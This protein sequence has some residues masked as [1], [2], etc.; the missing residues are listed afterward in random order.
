MQI[1]QHPGV[2][3]EQKNFHPSF[4]P[5]EHPQVKENSA[6]STALTIAAA[7]SFLARAPGARPVPDESRALCDWLLANYS[8]LTRFLAGSFNKPWGRALART[9]EAASIPGILAHYLARKGAIETLVAE[10][11]QRQLAVLGAGFDTLAVRMA[12][13]HP[14]WSVWE[15]DHPATQAWKVRAVM[16]CEFQKPNLQFLGRDFSTSEG[17]LLFEP[18][19]HH[20]TFWVA[21]GLLMYFPEAEAKEFF[22]TIRR[23]SKPGSRF[24]FT[25]ME[26]REDGTVDFRRR[27]RPLHLWLRSQKEPFRWGIHQEKLPEFLSPL[28]FRMLPISA[29]VIKEVDGLNVGEY[30]ALAEIP[31]S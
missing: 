18:D 26:P 14:E 5:A 28:G 10:G 22:Q 19:R 3:R 20:E 6:S 27:S 11:R 8:S 15:L 12:A 4:H 25:F 23:V 31:T 1:F 13:R 9:L 29:S 16:A 21:E 17:R 24:A 30:L 2:E 7:M